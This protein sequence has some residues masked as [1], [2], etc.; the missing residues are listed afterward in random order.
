MIVEHLGICEC[1]CERR[2]HNYGFAEC[3]SCRACRKFVTK[4]TDV[5]DIFDDEAEEEKFG[6]DD[7]DDD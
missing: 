7:E 1:G 2:L 6:K 5:P 3:R 4:R